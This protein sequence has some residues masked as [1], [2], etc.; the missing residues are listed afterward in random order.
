MAHHRHK[1]THRSDPLKQ[2]KN[3]LIVKGGGVLNRKVI[4]VVS[5]DVPRLMAEKV[6]YGST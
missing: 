6:V 2:E 5:C 4:T 3:N 1:M